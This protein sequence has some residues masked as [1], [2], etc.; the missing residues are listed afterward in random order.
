MKRKLI[1]A[2][3]TTAVVLLLLEAAARLLEARISSS[4]EHY[5]V[6]RGWQTEFFSSLFDWH[7]PDPDLLWRFKANLNN[8]LIK[9]NSEHLIGDEVSKKK[10]PGTFRI[11]LL[12]DSSPVG[13]GLK[14][15][16]LTF[17]EVLD[18]LLEIECGGDR[19]VEVVNAAVSGYTSEQIGRFLELRGWDYEPDL[20]LLYCGSNDASISGPYSDRELLEGQRLKTVRKLFNQFALYRVLRSVIVKY[21][22]NTD[23]AAESLKL[24]VTPG[25]FAENLQR[26]S[27]ACQDHNCPLVILKPPVPYFWPAGLQFKVFTHITGEDGRFIMPDAMASILARDIKYCLSEEICTRLYGH[28]DKFTGSV[29]RSAYSDSLSPAKAI[30]HYT[31]LVKNDK[32]NPVLLN[33]LG[34]S[35]WESGRYRE[36][37][38]YLRRARDA[39][40]DH[41]KRSKDP[42]LT[43]AGS[44][45]LFNIG[46]NLLSMNGESLS[47]FEDTSSV[48]F[49]FLDSALQADYFSLRIKRSYWERI[50][51]LKSRPNVIVVDLPR[52]FKEN[53]GERLFIDHCH[54]TAEGHLL[55]ARELFNVICTYITV[56]KVRL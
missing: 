49:A 15:H 16:K 8:P 48:A 12:G 21:I 20:I 53:G 41:V 56:M 46:V 2:A 43:A 18:R 29:Y 35:L 38:L 40:A 26:I 30:R 42:T 9:T 7:E 28:A 51:E 44:P 6:E 3:I 50:D 31:T 32:D 52:I 19:D 36:A 55:I 11:L 17:G 13:L 27:Q 10:R 1:F 14:S 4:A 39:F 47:L 24:R 54:P 5:A 45:F 37:D 33:N 34:V 25:R 22:K 23:S